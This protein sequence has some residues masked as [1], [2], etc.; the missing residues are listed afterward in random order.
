MEQQIEELKGV[1]QVYIRR[2]QEETQKSI[3]Y[4]ARIQ[5]L[6][7]QLEM[8]QT[9]SDGGNFGEPAKKVGRGKTAK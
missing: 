9:P 2:L 6:V 4:E 8:L 3:A 5:A 1:L 7:A